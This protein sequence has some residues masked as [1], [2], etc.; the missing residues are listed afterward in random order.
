LELTQGLLSQ[1]LE[2]LKKVESHLQARRQPLESTLASLDQTLEG[3]GLHLKK[4]LK[5]RVNSVMDRRSGKVGAAL[6]GFIRDHEPNWDR[7][8]LP[9]APATFRP[10]LYQ[11]FQECV[12]ELT[13]YV[14]AEANVSLVEFIREQEDWLRG[15]LTRVETP[16]LLSL[17]DALTLYYRQIEELGFPAAP[18]ALEMAANPR[19]SGLEVPLLNLQL[20]PGWWLDAEVWVRS[21]AG[22]LERYWEVLKRR[23]GLSAEVEPRRQLLR[24]LGRALKAIKEWLQEQVKVQLI[25]FEERL[26]FQYFLPLVDQWLKQQETALANTMRSLLTDLEG[27]AGTMQLEEEERAAK[28]RRLEELLPQARQIEIHL[29][30]MR[31]K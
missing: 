12:K 30:E 13:H 18:P 2:A 20:D 26:K 9:E 5:N 14:T 8:L 7:L 28:R 22:F 19:P 29:E 1:D 21:G 10:A 25:D 17:Q 15:E 31:Q 6:T 23:L 11:L 24:D 16:L 3:A 4:A 27:V